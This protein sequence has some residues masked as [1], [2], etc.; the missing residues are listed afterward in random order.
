MFRVTCNALTSIVAA[1][2][3]NVTALAGAA[4]AGPFE[5]GLAAFDRHDY[6]TARQLWRQL[7]EQGSAEA[8]SRLGLIYLLGLGVPQDY[9]H[10]AEWYRRAADQGNPSAQTSL[11]WMYR[12][13]QGVPQDYVLA[14]EW[15]RKAAD[16][17]DAPAQNNLG[18]MYQDGKGVPQDYAQAADWYRR[19]AEQGYHFAQANLGLMYD[20]GDG[21]LQDYVQAYKWLNLAASAFSLFMSIKAEKENYER[22][23]KSRDAVAAKMTPLQIAEAQKL[24]REWSRK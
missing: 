21:V 1:I 13:G 17:G 19:A 15:F 24:S 8:Q 4:I 7:A 20:R 18:L 12:E 10:A 14:V 5:D 3:L 6:A 2:L 22:V 16:H 9:A 23:V 11:G